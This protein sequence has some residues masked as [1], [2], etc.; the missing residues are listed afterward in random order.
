MVLS[1]DFY[2]LYV[3]II[4]LQNDNIIIFQSQIGAS[5]V[6]QIDVFIVVVLDIEQI[7]VDND[8][9]NHN[10]ETILNEEDNNAVQPDPDSNK[11]CWSVGK[12]ANW[13]IIKLGAWPG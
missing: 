12:S 4:F 13:D 8:S 11:A 7:V 1:S 5:F 6:G 2:K 10:L 9:P 3:C